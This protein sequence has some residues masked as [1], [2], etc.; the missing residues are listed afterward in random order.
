MRNSTET[1]WDGSAFETRLITRIVEGD[2]DTWKR[3]LTIV[4]D[5]TE[6]KRNELDLIAAK[7]LAEQASKAKSEFLANMSHEIRTPINGV[8]GMTE[9]LLGTN[10]DHKQ[11]RFADTVQNSGEALLNVIN[12]ILDFSK[13]EAGKL[14]LQDAAFDLRDLIEGSVELSAE[15]AHKKGLELA[16]RLPPDSPVAY[17][18]DAARLRQI[19]LNLLGNAV[20]FTEAG[21]VVL[22][23][24]AIEES[25]NA[26]I[27]RFDV[28]DT[29]IGIPPHS[30]ERIFESFAQADGS[31]T[32]HYGGTGLGL[33][34]ASQLT[35]L[36]GGEMGLESEQG[37][38][39]KFWFTV[40]LEK[41][42]EAAVDAD[43][44]GA[45][46][47]ARVLVIDDNETNRAIY[48]EQLDHWAAD[49]ECVTSAEA[50]L[51]LLRDA[52]AQRRPYDIVIIDTHTSGMDGMELARVASADP[53]LNATR[54]IV[55]SSMADLIPEHDRAEGVA[56]AYLTKP[57]RHAELLHCL[58]SVLDSTRTDVQ[59]THA[60]PVSASYTH[61]KGRVLLVEDNVV[62]QEIVLEFLSSTGLQI[63]VREDGALA[64][65][66]C[67]E[68]AYALVLMDCHL[69]VLDGFQAT[70][71]IRAAECGTR[72]P[73][74]ALTA[75]ALSGDRERCLEAGMDD[76]LSKPFAESDLFEVLVRWLPEG[77]VSADESQAESVRVPV[78]TAESVVDVAVLDRFRARERNGKPVLTRIIDAY[79]DQSARHVAQLRGAVAEGD[80][81]AVHF[82]AHS[83]KSS[84]ATVGAT[85]LS[86]LCDRMEG[87]ARVG[88][89][90]TGLAAVVE[91]LRTLH[92]AVCETLEN[93]RSRLCP[94]G[95]LKK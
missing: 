54:R 60:T 24:A 7:E 82:A 84:S 6:R 32:R 13:V 33:A 9:L 55:L 21:E 67:A 62:N 26:A 87:E 94:E 61:F 69:P 49:F 28:Q 36:M 89:D 18:G 70:Q 19:L 66:A 14:E 50:G 31:T 5:V 88:G 80:A 79:L 29:G 20:K 63:D 35:E 27:L 44:R 75:N 64:V 11:R 15:S 43:D 68:I 57:A 3:I 86:E 95:F 47:Q 12:D 51:E 45:L 76:Y 59:A 39:S 48:N 91:E 23:V 73:I 38:G 71:S 83:L 92:S 46:E 2:E 4:E 52:A 42:A 78:S 25:P 10:L 77:G 22:C 16:C 41:G 90:F 65:Q 17:R 93:E 56:H 53:A 30:Q 58:T 37:I 85:R 74:V 40:R 34:I 1:R 8:L 81:P 72:T